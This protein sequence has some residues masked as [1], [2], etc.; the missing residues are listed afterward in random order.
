M[1]YTR[2]FPFL[3]WFPLRKENVKADLIA[4]ATV[5]FLLVPQSMAYAQL[6]GLP[7]HY[8]LYTAFVPVIIASLFGWCSQLHTGPVAMVSLLTA[9]VLEES[10]LAVTGSPEYVALAIMLSLLAGVILL[11]LGLL[12]LAAVVNFFSHPVI[13]GFTNAGA[14]I[15]AMSQINL[16]LKLP[17]GRGDYFIKD[18][19]EMMMQTPDTHLPTLIFGALAI[20]FL[21]VT[22]KIRPKWPGA[23][24]VVFL[25]VA[26]SW[27]LSFDARFGGSVVGEIPKGLPAL[28]VPSASLNDIVK[29]L[30]GAFMVAM[31]GFLEVLAICKV[32]AAKTKE[33]LDMNQE[34]VGQGLSGILGSFSQAYPVS[35]SF[36]RSAL[37]LYAGAMTGMS[38]IFAAILVMIVLLFLTP[39]LYYLPR[40]VLGAIIVAAVIGLIDVKAFFRIWRTSRFDGVA[41]VV[42]FL[43]A[44]AMAPRITEGILIGAVLAIIFH[45]YQI[46][47]PDFNILGKDS[48][49]TLKDAERYDLKT[50]GKILAV[51]FRGRLV[52]ANASHFEES[53]LRA[54]SAKPD[55][56]AILLVASG[57]NSIDATGEETL[58]HIVEEFRK[59]G[60]EVFVSEAT[61][62]VLDVLKRTGLYNLIGEKY[63][64]ASA[65]Q[66]FDE[67]SR[68]YS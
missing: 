51:G 4:G 38:S 57:I 13:V 50:G 3:R 65:I 63:F 52:F 31:I 6:A 1:N 35:G 44:L 59:N 12:K 20:S 14:L 22:K 53:I 17:L 21:L 55:T 18:F 46:M 7:P 48:D 30:P 26:I 33:R 66:T 56:K 41:A 49:G 43:A 2:T 5:G 8:G 60:I 16:F 68:R 36:S 27:L 54:L 42:T 34:L 19:Y 37:N 32:I 67:L 25:S 40:A 39:F 10:H 58:R 29:L 9:A 62:R 28:K 45:L 11:V 24:I 61:D 15:I 23:L 47:K 64:S